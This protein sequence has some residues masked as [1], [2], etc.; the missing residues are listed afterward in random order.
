M[1]PVGFLLHRYI[2]LHGLQN[3]KFVIILIMYNRCYMLMWVGNGV[4][5]FKV[6]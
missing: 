1:H 4:L 5:Y 3:I 2:M 6:G